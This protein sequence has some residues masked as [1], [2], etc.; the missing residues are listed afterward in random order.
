MRK[1]KI[2]IG[3]RAI[4][5]DIHAGLDDAELMRAFG[6]S[7]QGLQKLFAKLVAA[8][9]ISQSEL[10]QR[11]LRS[12][13]S[14]V[15][16]LVDPPGSG[17]STALVNTS[18]AL[19]DIRAGMSDT[20]LM[21]KYNLSARGLENLFRKLT[22]AGAATLSDFSSRRAAGRRRSPIPVGEYDFPAD[23]SQH[24]RWLRVKS[25]ERL[26]MVFAAIAGLVGGVVLIGTILVLG[27]KVN[28]L[29]ARTQRVEHSE[30]ET[31]V[32]ALQEQAE[33][34]I[35]ILEEIIQHPP[36]SAL[37][38]IASSESVAEEYRECLENCEKSL[39]GSDD[40]DKALV[41]NCKKGCIGKYSERTR[42]IRERFYG[43]EVQK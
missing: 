33:E 2:R 30:L 9:Q 28:Y 13:R 17:R 20:E 24:H 35:A 22:D 8:A 41:L 10:D 11:A 38:G 36:T 5:R 40:M 12:T 26:R 14:H 15:V 7:A 37:S 34:M 18:D 19:A 39:P 4:V 23:D 21:E 1:P 29:S 6:L 43:T 3:K 25:R 31:T 32:K 16:E 27:Y 42:K